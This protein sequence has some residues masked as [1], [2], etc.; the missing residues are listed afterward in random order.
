MET[1]VQTLERQLKYSRS[2]QKDTRLIQELLQAQVQQL[3]QQIETL[4][5]Q[6]YAQGRSN[7]EA[8]AQVQALV[9]QVHAQESEAQAKLVELRLTVHGVRQMQWSTELDQS[10]QLEEAR[11]QL[12]EALEQLRSYEDA[13]R[14][15][16]QRS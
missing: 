2:I 13:Y 15:R 3:Q 9:Q 12:K 11:E 16:S 7:A 1:T 14:S 5:T 6:F 10:L 8:Q 4:A